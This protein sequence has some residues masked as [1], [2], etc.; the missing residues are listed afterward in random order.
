MLNEPPDKPTRK[1]HPLE[2][3]PQPSPGP[4]GGDGERR[5]QVM[6]HIPVVRPIVTYVLMAINIVIFVAGFVSP[7]LQQSL[8]V[9]GANNRMAVLM[10]GEHLRLVTAMFLH[11]GP[12]HIIFNMY[13]LYAIGGTVE[14][15]FGHARFLLVYAL[16]GLTGSLASILLNDPFTLSVGASGAVFA[17][18]GAEMIYL[19]QHR[20]LLGENGRRQLQS[21]AIVALLNLAIGFL[22]AVTPDGARIDNWGHVGGFIGGVV[23]T[24]YIGPLFLLRRHPEREG[25]YIAEDVNPLSGRYQVV[26]L[27]GAA[28]LAVLIV[29]TLLARS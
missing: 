23:L 21:L 26:S 12:A 16:G 24:W 9:S 1:R 19:Y 28:L 22:G 2:R 4:A 17:I 7:T 14:G 25:A 29:A 11:G 3:A 27:Y 20:K 13:A 5:Q 8:I 10:D 6:L 18:F 15:L